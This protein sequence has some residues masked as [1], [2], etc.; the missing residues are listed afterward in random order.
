[1]VISVSNL[2]KN[3]QVYQKQPGVLGSVRSFISRKY[4][5]VR[6]EDISFDIDE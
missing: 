6:G 3:Y 5:E 1:M 2:R 4:S